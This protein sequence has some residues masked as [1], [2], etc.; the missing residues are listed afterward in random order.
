MQVRRIVKHAHNHVLKHAR[1]RLPIRLPARLASRLLALLLPAALTGC[2]AG[3]F[4]TTP[5]A[6]AP[7]IT[8]PAPA[9][10]YSGPPF[11]IK[12]MAG[13]VPLV[14]ATVHFYSAGTTGLGS[15][16][17]ALGAAT[18]TDANGAA[19]IP[20]TYTCASATS[21]TYLIA[22]GG[23]VGS[24]ATS[25][26]N[27]ALLAAL[28][29]CNQITASAYVVNEVTSVGAMYALSPFYSAGSL[30]ASSTNLTGLTNAFATA[31]T[32]ANVAT[33]QSTGTALPSNAASP[34][35]RINSL[36]NV[37]N[38]CVVSAGAC[39]ALYAQSPGGTPANTLEALYDLA[40]YPARQPAAIF[41][42]S[43]Q[44]TAYT[45]ALTAAPLDWSVF[46]QLK[47]G[48]LN[49]P[50][51]I[52]VDSTGSV[53]VANYFYTATKLS[54][55][56]AA[57]FPGGITGYGLN[58]SFGLAVDAADN[59]Y[60]ANQQPYLNGNTIGSLTKLNSAGVSLSGAGGFTAGGFN[61]P[62]SVAL[63]PNGT[64]WVM[65]FGNSHVSV[66]TSGGTPLSGASGYTTPLFAFPVTVAVDGNHFGWIGNQFGSMVTRVAPDGSSFVNYQ[67]C[68]SASAIAFDAGNNAWITNFYGNSVSLISNAGAVVSNG[69]YTG[70]G[71]LNRPAGVAI[72][73]KGN[74][75][76][77]NYR[78]GYLTV[79]AGSTAASP[80]ASLTPATG[81]GGDANL[82]EAYGLAIDASGNVWVSNQG[83]DT[84][85]KFIG[86]ASPVKT[87]LLGLPVAP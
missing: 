16:S 12:V 59:V 78:A 66:L 32:L 82:L 39:G 33:G 2:G 11:S 30:G 57:V 18:T 60:I 21:L 31:A 48:G 50:G 19:G 27:V 64:V 68:N 67:C 41:A 26:G 38:A 74:V 6:P 83:S 15:A 28:G 69:A 53:W 47:G 85:T 61:Y 22:S 9:G 42:A 40:A 49:Y 25:N 3:N 52:A 75:F 13:G 81:L 65:E 17:T 77:S 7:P 86:L 79:L 54:P 80:G 63:D 35:A 24:S 58:N 23:K 55:V 51:S 73:G 34:A 4:F 62:T 29:P 36:A 37:L 87:P 56:G 84:V 71:A 45:P 70:A 72:D 46:L 10:S 5:V 20:A 14:G 44:S 76:V 1:A 8:P 43:L